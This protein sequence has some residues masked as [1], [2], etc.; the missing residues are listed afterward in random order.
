MD[1]L[2]P[3]QVHA[4]DQQYPGMLTPQWEVRGRRGDDPYQHDY[5][6]CS[7][8]GSI[9]PEDMLALIR[10]G[11]R[12]QGTDKGYKRYLLTP[13]PIAGQD[14]RIGSRH[15]PGVD[16]VI[17]GPAPA[18]IQQKFYLDHV[19]REQWREIV[20]AMPGTPGTPPA[21]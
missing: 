10:T 6:Q 17:R 20:S 1:V 4:H 3:A 21:A 8:C 13:N 12:L 15:G 5:R 14:C 16:E 7:Y 2:A 19:T 9:H 11:S 18:T